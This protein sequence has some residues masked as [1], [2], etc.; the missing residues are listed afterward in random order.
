MKKKIKLKSHKKSFIYEALIFI[1]HTAVEYTTQLYYFEIY[2][3]CVLIVSVRALESWCRSE[4]KFPYGAIN[5][6]LGE[7][8]LLLLVFF[9]CFF[10]LLFFPTHF[11]IGI[12]FVLR[13]LNSENHVGVL[14]MDKSCV[15]NRLE[16]W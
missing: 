5:F 15:C 7:L 13:T 11:F 9:L 16:I 12:S 10:L 4:E 14:N 8:L 3:I 2:Y 6:N 1:H